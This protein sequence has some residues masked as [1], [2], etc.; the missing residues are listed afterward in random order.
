MEMKRKIWAAAGQQTGNLWTS[1]DK[2]I[3]KEGG[4]DPLETLREAPLGFGLGSGFLGGPVK[5]LGRGRMS[6]VQPQDLLLKKA[7]VAGGRTMESSCQAQEPDRKGPL[8]DFSG[9]V[10]GA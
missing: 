1:G 5:G 9:S 10:T 6:Q 7:A 3:T 4:R 8:A 2:G